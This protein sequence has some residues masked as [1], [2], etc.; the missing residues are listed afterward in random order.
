[1]SKVPAVL[2]A[3]AVLWLAAYPAR[4]EAQNAFV[5]AVRELAATASVTDGAATGDLLPRRTA[6][7]ARVKTAIGEWDRAIKTLEQRVNRELRDATAE[8]AFQLRVELGL[9]YRQRGR[10][11]DALRE[12]DAAAVA[13]PGASDVHVLR[14]LTLVAAGKNAN[15]GAAFRMAWLRDAANPVKAYLA[16]TGS[17]QPELGTRGPGLD[18][19]DRE[20][21]RKVL[22]DAFERTLADGTQG[23]GAPFFVLDP[24]PDNLSRAPVVADAATAEVF[25]QLAGGKLDDALATWTAFGS[26]AATAHDDSPVAHFERGRA[27]E[28]QGRHADARRAYTAA[29]GGTLTGRYVLHV[30]IGRIALVEG[31]QDAAIEAFGHAARLNPNDPVVH[32]ELAAAYAATG[33]IEESFAELVA[34]LLIDPR[35]VEAIAAVGQLFLD[36]DRAADAVAVFSRSVALQP[37]RLETHYALAVALSRAGRTEEAARQFEQFQRMSRQAS[38]DRRREVTGQ[39][40]PNGVGR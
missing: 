36:T 38:E 39:A 33:R 27:A 26:T 22:R 3:A 15:A 24:V 10:L 11:D 28:I 18:P 14:A 35:D 6:A 19:A 20:R 32:R 17:H 34:A 29:L 37:D 40:G 30:G 1:M 5:D 25:A 9:A 2:A 13:Q 21:A 7:L 12:F 4:A 23:R 31:D 16:L 8:R